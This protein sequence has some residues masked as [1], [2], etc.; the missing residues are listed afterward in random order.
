MGGLVRQKE[1]EIGGMGSGP[2][3]SLQ[4]FVPLLAQVPMGKRL[5]VAC[6]S[7]TNALEETGINRLWISI[8]P[9][10]RTTIGGTE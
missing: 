3:S 9:R 1:F 5:P 6:G 8:G 2:E 7:E 10:V 4:D